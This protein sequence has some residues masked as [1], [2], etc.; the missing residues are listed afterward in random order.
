MKIGVLCDR[1]RRL[2]D[3]GENRLGTV[4]KMYALGWTI[5]ADAWK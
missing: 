3:L 5:R 1:F 2:F 4:A